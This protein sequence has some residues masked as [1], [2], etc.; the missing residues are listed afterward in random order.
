LSNFK[1]VGKHF[2]QNS[3]ETD[4]KQT[5]S[6]PYQQMDFKKLKKKIRATKVSSIL[7]NLWD[8]NKKSIG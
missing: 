8:S 6:I 5:K 7:P 4:L 1:L 2:K 3:S